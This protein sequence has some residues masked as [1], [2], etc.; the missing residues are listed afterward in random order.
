LVDWKGV[1]GSTILLIWE[2]VVL[3]EITFTPPTHTHTQN[4][5]PEYF[6]DL[7]SWTVSP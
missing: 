1:P 5:S 6:A 7:E 2:H 4:T 3:G